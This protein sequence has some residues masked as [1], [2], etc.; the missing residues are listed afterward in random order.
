MLMARVGLC[1]PV[2]W[3]GMVLTSRPGRLGERTSALAGLISGGPISWY[4]LMGTSLLSL[5]RL[6]TTPRSMKRLP[7]AE[8]VSCPESMCTYRW[9][10]LGASLARWT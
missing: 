3:P 7:S 8:G 10:R 5:V 2:F 9:T 1:C 4:G 6:S